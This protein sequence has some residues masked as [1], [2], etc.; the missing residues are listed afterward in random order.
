MLQHGPAKK[1]TVYVGEAVKH[2][3]EPVYISVLNYLFYHGVSGAT[4]LRGAAGFGAD[5]QLQMARFVDTSLNLPIK[6]EFVDTPAKVDEILPKLIEIVDNGLVTV[7]DTTIVKATGAA[8]APALVPA[9]LAGRAK[10]MR[11]FIGE[12]DKWRGKHLYDAVLESLRAHDIAGATI[13]RGICGYGAH[14]RIHKEKRMRLSSDLPITIAV[15]EEEEKL[16]RYLPVLEQMLD[17]G[18]VALSDVDVI[19]YTH[20]LESRAASEVQP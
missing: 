17:G 14:S 15:V 8:E 3:H 12:G 6:I 11:I 10:L 19:K 16:R 13:Y 5:H 9:A 18:L 20:R 4:V 7:D 2:K 1:V